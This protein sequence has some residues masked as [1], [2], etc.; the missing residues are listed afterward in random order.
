M[1]FIGS[2]IK[3]RYEI[4]EKFL[5]C[6]FSILYKALDKNSGGPCLI[7][8]FHEEVPARTPQQRLAC[9]TQIIMEGNFL[10]ALSNP[11]LP[12]VNESIEE[13]ERVYLVFENIEGRTLDQYVKQQKGE[14]QSES[15]IQSFFLQFIDVLRYLH[16][17]TPPII[18]GGISPEG[19]VLTPDNRL[20]FTE[21]AMT[22][23]GQTI[24]TGRTNFRVLADKQFAALEQLMGEPAV[25]VNDIYSVGAI[26]Y[27]LATG[28]K[29]RSSSD[30]MKNPAADKKI[31]ELNPGISK[32]MEKIILKAMDPDKTKRYQNV[33]ELEKDLLDKFPMNVQMTVA[34]PNLMERMT[35][36]Q[37]DLGATKHTVYITGPDSSS[38]T[39]PRMHV[40]AQPTVIQ[41]KETE[42]EPVLTAVD[43]APYQPVS[44]AYSSPEELEEAY[45]ELEELGLEDLSE[46]EAKEIKEVKKKFQWARLM[47]QSFWFGSKQAVRVAPDVSTPGSGFLAQ[48]PSID[49]SKT[50]IDR[51]VSHIIPEK[52]AKAIVGIVVSE[53]ENNELKLAVKDPSNVYIYDQIAFATKDQYKPLLYRADPQM[54]ELAIEYVYSLPAGTSGVTWFEWLEKKKYEFDSIDVKQDAIQMS[55]FGKDEI[56]GPV[57]E[58][59]NRI[60]KEA[61][62]IGASDIHLEAF[63]KEMFVRYRIDGVLHTMNTYSPEIAKAIV[64]RIKITASMDIAQEKITQGGRISVKV[65]DREFD[66]RVSIIPVPHGECVVMRLLNKGAFNYALTDL[67]FRE[68]HLESFRTLLSRPYGMILA[69]GPTGSGK[70]TT[71]YASLKEI[72]RPDRKLLTVEDPIEYE[73]PGI[74]QVQ[75]NL[76]PRE[77][78][79]KVTFAKALREFLRQD[80]DVILVGEIRDPETAQIAVQASLT[81]HL[82]LST[83]HTNDS[84]G[85]V[86]RFRDMGVPPYLIGSV[87]VGGIAQRLVR[88]ICDRCKE[89]YELTAADKAMFDEY[90]VEPKNVSIGKGCLKCHTVGYKGRMG[91]Y[92]IFSVTPDVGEMI[93]MGKTAEEIR[94]VAEGRGMKNLVYDALIKAAQGDIT[95]TE[96]RRVTT[97]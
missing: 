47:H 36:M 24:S 43:Q 19:I 18:V 45:E 65:A 28:T 95:M 54:I 35:Q 11:H 30:R 53:G 60:I 71:L 9:R 55:L 17:Q 44:P 58:E 80:P 87:L 2:L 8:A 72:A 37:D 15:V 81:G 61:I 14:I 57:I 26:M 12:V 79:K 31:S 20:V 32:D 92:E 78:D 90:Q 86:T 83:I 89:K 48:Y 51:D 41:E 94:K 88:K 4:K 21:F 7:R 84:V 76:A 42:A 52:A 59:A 74:C 63:E 97:G 25:P 64:K 27:F 82:L 93:S 50:K 6:R 56:D 68:D 5:I 70:S 23:I 96:V 66:L 40:P 13:G 46:E 49:L 69:S 85:I 33:D 34:V 67:G 39:T 10:Q 73:M 77:D 75:V 16:E 29:P 22:R 38:I 91:I 1:A 62:S 3:N